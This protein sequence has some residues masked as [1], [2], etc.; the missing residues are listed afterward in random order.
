METWQ[1]DHINSHLPKLLANTICSNTFLATLQSKQILSSED[2]DLIQSEKARIDK[3]SL[4]YKIILTRKNSYDILLSA[5]IETKQSGAHFILNASFVEFNRIIDLEYQK[6]KRL[7]K[8]SGNGDF[9]FYA[10]KFGNRHTAVRRERYL[11]NSE[12]ATTRIKQEIT[13]LTKLDC[14]KNIVRYFTCKID[15]DLQHILLVFELCSSTLENLICGE[16]QQ[17]PKH[18]KI[19][20]L[21]QLTSALRFLHSQNLIYLN[22]RPSSILIS[23]DLP[24]KLRPKF[25]NFRSAT[26]SSP[27]GI[28]NVAS[29]ILW[30]NRDWLPGSIQLSLSDNL[31]EINVVSA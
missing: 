21:K 26:Y 25:S 18:S 31:K 12:S 24:C 19:S 2:N 28:S 16:N 1:I 22:I 8:T 6:E 11:A 27:D 4:L 13:L 5:L 14:Q 15:E 29:E 20:I 23:N 30:K 9:V 3:A 17:L 7:G 10:G